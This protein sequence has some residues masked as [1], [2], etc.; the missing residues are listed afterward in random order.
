[1]IM[2]SIDG[3]EFGSGLAAGTMSSLISSGVEFIGDIGT[4]KGFTFNMINET[5]NVTNQQII[6]IEGPLRSFNSDLFKAINIV[7]GGLSGGI[8][9]TITRGNFWQG[10]RQG[11][12][13]SGINHGLHSLVGPQKFTFEK[14]TET[15][16]NI[17]EVSYVGVDALGGGLSLGKIEIYT[18]KYD[19]NI[20]EG[21][22]GQ[23]VATELG[24]TGEFSVNPDSVPTNGKIKPGV[25]LFN[26]MRGKITFN[27]TKSGYSLI[28]FF[29]DTSTIM[30]Q[31]GGSAIFFGTMKGYD[32]NNNLIWSSSIKG[33]GIS[34]GF[35]RSVFDVEF[36]QIKY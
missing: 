15:S 21:L 30:S 27:V 31:K 14:G 4:K 26:G 9:S 35:T 11:L 34:F 8:S 3:G 13:T 23:K 17:W 6:T 7:A 24:L 10:A 32:K 19:K 16:I 22:R 5:T 33:G 29:K 20:P 12:I 1:M 18:T 36:Q 28:D 25:S 2:S